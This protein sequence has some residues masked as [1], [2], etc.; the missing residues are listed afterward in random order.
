MRTGHYSVATPRRDL[1]EALKRDVYSSFLRASVAILFVHARL[2]NRGM[3][4]ITN[5]I[6]NRCRTGKVMGA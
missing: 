5:Q 1:R 3:K 6:I 2:F 4:I